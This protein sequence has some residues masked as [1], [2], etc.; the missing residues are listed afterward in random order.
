MIGISKDQVWFE[1]PDLAL[2]Y[3]HVE[4]SGCIH[5]SEAACR[6]L[7]YVYLFAVS[8]RSTFVELPVLEGEG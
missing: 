2:R 8:K 7:E 1:S 3:K 6:P 5:L 4:R